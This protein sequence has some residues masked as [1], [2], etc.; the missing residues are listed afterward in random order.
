MNLLPRQ[1]AKKIKQESSMRMIIIVC[2]LV[3]I[4]EGVAIFMLAPSYVLVRSERDS[5]LESVEQLKKTISGK[6]SIDDELKG[7][8]KDIKEFIANEDTGDKKI[9]V[10][11]NSVLSLRPQGVSTNSLSIIE[12]KNGKVIQM[13]GVGDTREALIEYERLLKSQDYVKDAKYTD[14]F[15]MK[16]SNINYNLII[17]IK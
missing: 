7:V 8:S 11:L 17:S 9:T 5:L 10:L 4:L 2:F 16:K 3:A 6:G 15:I 13:T 12:D 14:R 1:E